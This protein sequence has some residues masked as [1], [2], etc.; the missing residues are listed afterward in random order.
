MNVLLKIVKYVEEERGNNF[1]VGERER[2]VCYTCV[3]NFCGVILLVFNVIVFNI[4]SDSKVTSLMYKNFCNNNVLI[5]TGRKLR[6]EIAT[7]T[8][9]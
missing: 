2:G 7:G 3:T 4:N 9:I 6:Y 5:L 8:K 1:E